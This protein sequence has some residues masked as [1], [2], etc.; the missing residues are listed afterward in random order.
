MLESKQ[1]ISDVKIEP[2]HLMLSSHGLELQRDKTSTLQVNVGFLCNQ[3]CRH[4]HLDAGPDRAENMTR[5]TMMTVVDYARRSHFD[6][7]DITGGAPELNPHVEELIKQMAALVPRVMFRSNLSALNSGKRES[8]MQVLKA[9]QVVVVASLP[10]L[11]ASQTESQRGKGIFDISIEAL[12][13]LNGLGY[14]KEGSGLELNL[15]SNPSGAFMPAAQDQTE[16]RFRRILGKN[17]GIHFNSLF[18]FANVPLGRYREWLMRSGNFA[19]YM[20]KLASSFN[21]CA[22]S[23]VMCRTMVSVSWDGYLYDCDFNL[24]RGIY[25]GGQKIHVSEMKDHPEPGSLVATADH[26]YACTAGSG[27]T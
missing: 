10:S 3:K 9:H 26:C 1:T 11:N 19:L 8:L 6:V 16:K 23:N 15:V 22:V 25:M 7:I 5:E 27:F 14:G 4:C 12:Q 13:K 20:E 18:T 21:S 24:A 2:F 17:W